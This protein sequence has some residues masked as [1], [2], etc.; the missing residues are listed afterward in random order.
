MK[1]ALLDSWQDGETVMNTWVQFIRGGQFIRY[2][3]LQAATDVA[4]SQLYPEKLVAYLS[5]LLGAML[6]V[7]DSLWRYTYQM[8]YAC[9]LIVNNPRDRC[10]L[11][12]SKQLTSHKGRQEKELFESF[13]GIEYWPDSVGEYSSSRP[14]VN[15]PA[16]VR[17]IDALLLR[18]EQ[19][20]C[21]HRTLDKT[22]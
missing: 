17:G 7:V 4:L 9:D 8:R 18:Y 10:Q 5:H 6:D 22:T 15:Y 16:G 3:E 12:L 2:L 14:G 1:S 20:W 19:T 13:S 11:E 21:N